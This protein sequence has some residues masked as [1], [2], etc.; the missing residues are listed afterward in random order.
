MTYFHT[1]IVFLTASVYFKFIIS[2]MYIQ[3]TNSKY[4]STVINYLYY[5]PLFIFNK[6][7]MLIQKHI[8]QFH[9][10]LKYCF[11]RHIRISNK[12]NSL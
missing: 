9:K 8:F 7:I 2:K 4:L 10:F 3:N 6:I 5:F 1:I 11:R 12:L